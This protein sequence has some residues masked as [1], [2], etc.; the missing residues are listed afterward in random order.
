MEGVDRRQLKRRGPLR[1]HEQLAEILARAEAVANVAER[2]LLA[3]DRSPRCHAIAQQL[4]PAA[5][6]IDMAALDG[7]PKLTVADLGDG[8]HHGASSR[9]RHA[10]GLLQVAL[11]RSEEH[12]SELQS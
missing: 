7:E 11:I 2:L 1:M 4:T 9:E 12:T 5:Q 3:L 10:A 8:A 6:R